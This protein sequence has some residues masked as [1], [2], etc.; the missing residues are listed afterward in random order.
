MSGLLKP[1][2]PPVPSLAHA[3]PFLFF[4]VFATGCSGDGDTLNSRPHACGRRRG[5]Q[6]LAADPF[7]RLMRTAT[8]SPQTGGTLARGTVLG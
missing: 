5:G 8:G 1:E 3:G 2:R 6:A 4:F 7:D